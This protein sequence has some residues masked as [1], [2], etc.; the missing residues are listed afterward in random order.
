MNTLY[1]IGI[2]HHNR[3]GQSKLESVLKEL[4]PD[5]ILIE[6]SPSIYEEK[7]I[8][9]EF[10]R[11]HLNRLKG[12]SRRRSLIN[13]LSL[14]KYEYKVVEKFCSENSCE[15]NYL[16]DI[17]LST[18]KKKLE[19]DAIE[20]INTHN[21]LTPEQISEGYKEFIRKND[22]I[23]AEAR[24]YIKENK[25]RELCSIYELYGTGEYVLGE[26]DKKMKKTLEM[27]YE[28]MK[29]KVIATVTGFW[30]IINDPE[31]KSFYC[32]TSNLN[33]KRI[34]AI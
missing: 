7:R 15:F 25:E 3:E 28:I 34:F 30:H 33:R 17:E 31:Q 27:H 12:K 16:N 11:I 18:S 14:D 23:L 32:I 19:L 1:E 6:G 4:R 8:Y 2:Y 29:E 21:S 22:K 24:K 9:M 5:L 13:I 26:R 20:I 10:L